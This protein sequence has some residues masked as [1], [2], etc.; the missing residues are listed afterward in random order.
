MIAT[1]R[2]AGWLTAPVFD[3]PEKTRI[4]SLLHTILWMILVASVMAGLVLAVLDP[5]D[6]LISLAF[7]GAL[8]LV[9]VG[10]LRLLAIGH[11][12]TTS[13]VLCTYLLAQVTAGTATFGGLMAPSYSSML[14]VI[15]ISS[16]VL[17]RRAARWLSAVI[18]VVTT[19]FYLLAL[20]GSPAA[21][22][23]NLTVVW[24][25]TS[26]NLAVAAVLMD[27]ASSGTSA[28]LQRVQA[29]ERRYRDL[30]E[31]A[32][33]GILIASQDGMIVNAN[34]Q[35][36]ALF[37]YPLNRF[38]QQ[39]LDD[40]SDDGD[41]LSQQLPAL[42]AQTHYMER[43]VKRSDGT[44][45]L[46]EVSAKRLPD[47]T[48]QFILRDISQRHEAQ[49]A[50]QNS[51]RRFRALTE[52]L[53]E[54]ITLIT[55]EGMVI[56]CSP[57]TQEI[58]GYSPDDLIG[59]MRTDLIHPDDREMVLRQTAMLLQT[60][61]GHYRTTFRFL[62]KQGYWM[63]VDVV[64]TNLVDDPAVGAVVLNYRDITERKEMEDTLLELNRMYH[65]LSESNQA[66]VRATSEESLF[67]AVCEVIVKVGDYAAA[68]VETP[69][70]AQPH[71]LTTQPAH[72]DDDFAQERSAAQAVCQTGAFQHLQYPASA[73]GIAAFLALPIRAEGRVIGA[74]SICA[75]AS[76]AFSEDDIILL[77]ELAGDIGY[78]LSSLAAHEQVQ[79]SEE[80]LRAVFDRL[81][82]AIVLV[83]GET[84]IIRQVNSAIASILGYNADELP[85]K[86]FTTLFDPSSYDTAHALLERLR[87]GDSHLET[88]ILPHADGTTRPIEFT[89]ARIRWRG[90]RTFLVVMRD[91]TER[92]QLEQERMAAEIMRVETQ[93]ERE[94]LSLKERFLSVVSHEFRTPLSVILSSAEILQ[95]F[96]D[97]LTPERHDTHVSR[98]RQ[99]ADFMRRLMD[100]VLT[101]SQAQAGQLK[102][103]PAHF[104]LIPFCEGIIEQVQMSS[105]KEH[106][107]E[108][109]LPAHVDDVFMDRRLLQH[110]LLNLLSN[111]AKYS[112]AG[113]RVA[114]DITQDGDRL[115]FVVSDEGMGIPAADQARLFEAF[116][117][118]SNAQN[119]QG[120]GLGLSIVRSSVEVHNDEISFVSA[121]GAG[122]VFT[123]RLPYLPPEAP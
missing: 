103:S 25:F 64:I 101:V 71:G 55:S 91:I 51:E 38:R 62:H 116:H 97:R 44:A 5:P 90:N 77:K 1:N 23:A 73:R 117:R 48:F 85:G 9:A 2:L 27:I 7:A 20:Q 14:I 79:Q 118:A 26:F 112:P 66:L 24:I 93:K 94:V 52:K 113:T 53:S 43:R 18:I 22:P 46:A 37:G 83:E 98:I 30:M 12:F 11:V 78:G 108:L 8:A 72:K 89:G 84:G 39:R 75:S 63:W 36:C 45:F 16:L 88:V 95:I 114:L 76:R 102:F 29:S 123:V 87:S 68:W 67:R 74:L 10:L 34:A 120:T 28:I 3:D 104:A 96:K 115:V 17:P 81:P 13:V 61:G 65:T 100:D 54:C 59:Q 42:T 80:Q 99:Q 47:D 33:D 109:S 110:I 111:A 122:T 49:M 60:P 58:L 69:G 15:V 119:V 19:L 86:P 121:E 32:A 50:I 4:A 35:A 40:L 6:L 70:N 41:P 105:G 92:Q 107:V 82:D 106:R 56:Y 57:T 31:Q 21:T